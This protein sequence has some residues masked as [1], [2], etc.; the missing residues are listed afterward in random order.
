MLHLNLAL[1]PQIVDLPLLGAA[2]HSKPWKRAIHHF[3]AEH[4]GPTLAYR[5]LMT[6]SNDDHDD[7][8]GD[9]NHNDGNEKELLIAPLATDD[10][11]VR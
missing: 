10:C 11:F 1:E 9:D 4:R 3:P 2:T 7:V 6:T 8:D 5:L